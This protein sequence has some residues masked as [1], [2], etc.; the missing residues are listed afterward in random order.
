MFSNSRENQLRAVHRVLT[1]AR[2]QAYLGVSS[3]ELGRILDDAEYL[4]ALVLRSDHQDDEEF[5][6]LLHQ[7]E[8]RYPG[9]AEVSAGYGVDE[10]SVSAPILLK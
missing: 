3:Q 1:R 4:L 2:S 5:G 6:L 10:E 7:M 8:S 9:F